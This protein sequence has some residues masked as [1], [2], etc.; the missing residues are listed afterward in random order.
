ML[1]QVQSEF[2]LLKEETNAINKNIME[3]ITINKSIQATQTKDGLEQKMVN[4]SGYLNYSW[5]AWTWKCSH[6]VAQK[7]GMRAIYRYFVPKQTES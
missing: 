1:N 3:L 5:S 2:I 6:W 4:N 7:T